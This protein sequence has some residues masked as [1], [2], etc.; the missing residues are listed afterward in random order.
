[1]HRLQER[2]RTIIDSGSDGNCRSPMKRHELRTSAVRESASLAAAAA[3][4][5]A[6]VIPVAAGFA[7]LTPQVADARGLLDEAK[8]FSDEKEIEASKKRRK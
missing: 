7:A 1:M 4:A 6:A 2:E 8:Y 3:F 5:S